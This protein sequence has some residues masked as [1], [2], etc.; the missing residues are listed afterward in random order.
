MTNT[1]TLPEMG[2][3][4]ES[5]RDYLYNHPTPYGVCQKCGAKLE[6]VWFTQ[7]EVKYVQGAPVKTG[8]TKM[9]VSHI[10]CPCCGR[11][12]PVDDSFDEPWS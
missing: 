3:S 10:E 7:E 6:A 9:A 5:I 8:R 2:F 12:Y 4:Q 11:E 1:A